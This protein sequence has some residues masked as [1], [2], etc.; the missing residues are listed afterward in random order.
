MRLT[1]VVTRSLLA[2]V[3][4]AAPSV[5]SAFEKD[6]IPT[7]AG[8]LEITFI[9]HG[10]L[11][12]GFAGKVV[13]V[14]PF[15]RLA[16]YATLPKADLVRV[17]HAHGD[18]LDPVALAAVRKPDTD[19]IV[20][21]VCAGKVA[22]AQ[23]LQNGES[24]SVLGIEVTAVPAYNLVHKR[25]DG[26]PFHPKGEGNGYVLSF[27]GTRVYVAGDTENTPEMKALAGLDV[28]FLP[29]NLPYTMTPEMV[30]DAARAMKPHILYP[31]HYGDT[32]PARLVELL[33]DEKSIEVRVR[34]MK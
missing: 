9:G 7:S 16:D 33:R 28:A 8:P 3:A 20:A 29:M 24:L 4:L 11:M 14:D 2:V 34:P 19:V 12:F 13:H 18:H 17:T 15:S 1:W 32:D 27:A 31:Y 30:A 5:A 22:G 10:T 21:P 6:V 26:S 23:V 25:E